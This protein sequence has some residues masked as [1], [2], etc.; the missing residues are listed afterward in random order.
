M[1]NR[2]APASA[3]HPLAWADALTQFGRTEQAGGAVL[4]IALAAALLWA[5]LSAHGYVSLWSHSSG[6]LHS[7]LD[8]TGL[9]TVADLVD[10]GLM[11]IFFLAVGLEIG[12]EV[13]EGSLQDR[14]NALLPVVAALCGMAGAAVVYL[15]VAAGLHPPDSIV[16]GW[17]VPMATDVAFTLGAVALL[18]TRVPRPLRVFVLALAV[19]DD[20][21][22]VIVLAV[23]ASQR[24][25]LGWLLATV[26]LFG[27]V[28]LL[29]RRV[30]H[31]WWPYVLAAVIAWYFFLRAGIEPTL[32]GAFVGI[33]I[34]ATAATRA[35]RRL[36]GPVHALSSFVVLPLFV[37]A[38]AGITF[39]NALWRSNDAVSVLVAII[40]ARTLGKMLG[41]TLGTALVIGLGVCR[42]PDGTTWRHLIGI[43]LLCG[44]G[45]TVPLL[46]AHA[47]FGAGSSRFAGAQLGLL[48]GTG[49]AALL[50]AAVLLGARPTPPPDL[51]RATVR[52]ADAL[53][54]DEEG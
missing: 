18:G 4:V 35:G 50:G 26:A 3:W 11:T 51:A 34:P 16:K 1:A 24:P 5:N 43:S 38:N 42:L 36:E 54:P 39:T 14:R 30:H 40:S 45:I 2:R 31:A 29:R 23:V 46:F 32:S 21:A 49:A 22:S 53:H 9:R 52:A 48:I 41:I 8:S 15:I 28:A 12:R 27:A 33:L 37:L 19:A 10:N 20:V 47:V 25:H 13:A 17:G 7:A 6:A 44:M